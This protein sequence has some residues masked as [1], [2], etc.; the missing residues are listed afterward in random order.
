M[1]EEDESPETE[2][3]EEEDEESGPS[4]AWQN[5]AAKTSDLAERPGF[6]NPANKG[7]KAMKKKRKKKKR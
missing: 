3:P 1:S 5:P 2:G 6:R 7:S 4:K